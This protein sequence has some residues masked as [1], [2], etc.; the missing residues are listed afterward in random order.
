MGWGLGAEIAHAQGQS[1]A[2]QNS[3]P[4]NPPIVSAPPK[5]MPMS[6]ADRERAIEKQRRGV[7]LDEFGCTKYVDDGEIIVCGPDAERARQRVGPPVGEKG[8]KR[9]ASAAVRAA[10]CMPGDR[11][12][13]DPPTGGK[14]FGYVPPYPPDYREVMK[15]LPEPDMV[16]QEGSVDSAGN[17]HNDAKAD[18]SETPV[19]PK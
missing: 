5:D 1:A 11:I 17:I 8:P 2:V 16:V 13:R 9:K 14:P 19:P 3:P 4:Q 10:G 12:C 15:G 18:G 6:D 7:A